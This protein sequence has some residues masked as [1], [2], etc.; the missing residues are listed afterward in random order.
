M[1]S[2]DLNSSSS[3]DRRL[4]ALL[5][6][7]QPEVPDQGFATRVLAALP[8]KKSAHRAPSRGVM[9]AFGAATGVAFA[10]GRGVALGDL[11][12]ATD[13]LNDSLAAVSPL[14]ANP[15]LFVALALT[16]VSLLIAFRPGNRRALI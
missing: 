5:R 1:E 2:P 14:V 7:G 16:V 6:Q 8:E 3:D 15:W 10:M 12:A 4:E 13:R 11:E 9:C